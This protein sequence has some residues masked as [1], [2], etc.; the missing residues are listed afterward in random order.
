MKYFALLSVVLC[1]SNLATLSKAQA[2]LILTWNDYDLPPHDYYEGLPTDPASVL[3]RQI[4]SGQKQPDTSSGRNYL[5]WL[6]RELQVPVE[7]QMLVF[8]KT[9]LQRK[10][11][12]PATPRALYFNDQTAVTWIQDGMIEIQSFD[13]RRGPIFYILEG[14]Q[15]REKL[16]P[17]KFARRE[18]CLEGC[19]AGSATNYLPGL[20]A[21]S[22][23]VNEL[24][25]PTRV[26]A[27]GLAVNA[28]SAHENMSH[29]MPIQER[30]GGWVVTGAPQ[31][32]QHLG[33][34]LVPKE[35]A[36][37]PLPSLQN[38]EPIL[39]HGTSSH[40]VTLLLHDHQVGVMNKLYEAYYRWRT[41]RFYAEK[42]RLGW[43]DPHSTTLADPKSHKVY[44]SLE[45]LIAELLYQKE[46]PLPAVT[47]SADAAFLKVFQSK[48]HKT[49]D[50]RSLRELDLHTRL[51]KYRCSHLIYSSQLG[52]ME[53]DFK[54]TVHVALSAALK[55]ESPLASHL[56]KTERQAIHQILQ[57]TLPDYQAVSAT[58]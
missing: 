31:S 20:L 6:L 10:V 29:A 30:W 45:R 32:L 1:L 7:S 44:E 11:V 14:T 34:I 35:G 47:V 9:G 4:Q 51:Q 3:W 24:G 38:M 33:N 19:H 27:V 40:V 26:D 57:E 16:G 48:A 43:N 50:G 17:V 5:L 37:L 55:G 53:T 25:Q 36:V 54:R 56:P 21:R 8:S 58:P 18:S 52:G 23:H 13:P 41:Q 2:G 49:Q 28:I 22:L 42:L 39:P 12:T 46:A 15:S